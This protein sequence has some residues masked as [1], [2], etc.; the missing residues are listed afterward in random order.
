MGCRLQPD[1]GGCVFR[2]MDFENYQRQKAEKVQNI[3]KTAIKGANYDWQPPIFVA[4]GCRRRAAFAFEY[5]RGK[6]VLGFNESRSGRIV[7]LDHCLAL[8]PAVNDVLPAIRGLLNELCAITP[9]KKK[10]QKNMPITAGDILVLAADNGLDIVLETEGV[11]ELP[12]REAVFEFMQ[13]ET[14]VLRFCVRRKGQETAEPIIEKA[15]P[16]VKI[17]GI[18]VSVA[19][20]MFLQPSKAGEDVLVGLVMAYLGNC[21]GKIADLF[22]G[23][24]TFSYPLAQ[25]KQNHIVAVDISK[26]LLA[27]FEQTVHQHMIQN[28]QIMQRNLFKYPLEN[29]DLEGFKAVVFDPPRA[30]AA[31]QVEALAQI[32]PEK[33]PEKIVAV[34]CN[35]HSFVNDA[36]VLIAAGYKLKE[37]RMV[38]QFVYTNHSEL[39]ALFEK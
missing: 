26:G 39:V 3:L 24:G 27:K 15:K 13:R 31:K 6:L 10:K 20:G 18:D 30:G 32:E 17:G 2:D 4:D 8:T 37:V 22:C 35:P 9:V 16:I 33:R 28:V 12:Q 11:F 38:D 23:I 34:S 1:C 14:A 29:V 7:D 19:P 36:N 5:N 21:E 25:N